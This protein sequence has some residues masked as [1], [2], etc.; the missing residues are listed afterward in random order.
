MDNIKDLLFKIGIFDK[1]YHGDCS[2]DEN[3]DEEPR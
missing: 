1:E 3:N 2:E